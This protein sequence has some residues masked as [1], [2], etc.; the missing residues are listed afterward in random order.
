MPIMAMKHEV[1][2]RDELLDDLGD[3]SGYEVTNNQILCAVY[4]RPNITSGGIY[5]TDKTVDEDRFQGKAALVV[6]MG[7]QA[8]VDTDNWRFDV[9]AKVGDW[10]VFRPSDGW[11][12]TLPSKTAKSRKDGVLCRMLDDIHMRMIIPN[13]DAIW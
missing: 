5:L 6:K 8:F 1:D 2:P 13:P 7:P 3:L 10:I 11:N 9:K 4:I 12:I